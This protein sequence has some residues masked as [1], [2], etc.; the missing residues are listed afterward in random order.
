VAGDSAAAYESD[1]ELPLAGNERRGVERPE[2]SGRRLVCAAAV[3]F[4]S[5]VSSVIAHAD[6]RAVLELF[7]SQGCSS[8]PAADKVLGEFAADPTVIALTLSIN[9]WDYLGWKDT[10]ALAG[11]AKRQKAY[12]LVRHDR[13]VYTPQMIVNG[14]KHVLGS[15]KEAIERAIASTQTVAGALSLP[16]S[17]TVADGKIGVKV[18]AG[19]IELSATER[20]EVWLCPVS[21]SVPVTIARGENNGRTVTYH[22]V[23]RRWV[24]LGEWTGKAESWNIPLADFVNRD[25]IDRAAVLVQRGP[26]TS[27]SLILGAAMTALK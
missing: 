11:H 26:A 12:A 19:A 6:P 8:C 20:V 5:A 1:V 27:P 7:T 14:M 23:V 4:A 18:P 2:M 15:D 3:V 25:D 10:L 21:K 16:V 9:Y 17:L 24:K 22:N 13:E